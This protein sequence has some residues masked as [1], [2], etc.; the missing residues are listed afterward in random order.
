MG[1]ARF[2]LTLCRLYI[3]MTKEDGIVLSGF[4]I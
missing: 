4:A 1:N 3:K 2:T